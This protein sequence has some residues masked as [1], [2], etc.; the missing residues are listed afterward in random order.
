MENIYTANIKEVNNQKLYFVKKLNSFPELENVEPV[1]H[2][3]GMHKNFYRAC[4]MAQVYDEKIIEK[5][6]NE[7]HIVPDSDVAM[8]AAKS[9]S[10][11]GALVKN[12]NHLL[13]WFRIA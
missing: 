10:F 4:E 7:L 1:L 12:T 9:K 2:S 5:L 8:E 13:S 11:F 3:M 6:Y